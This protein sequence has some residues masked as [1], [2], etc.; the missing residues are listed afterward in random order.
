MYEQ[1]TGSLPGIGSTRNA[2]SRQQ[3]IGF[4]GLGRMGSAMAANLASAGHRITAY[5]RHHDQMDKMAKLG[6]DPTA[7]ITRLFGCEIVISM[8]PDD[9]A[10]RDVVFGNKDA[11]AKVWPR[12][13]RPAPVISRWSRSAPRRRLAPRASMRVASWYM[14]QRRGF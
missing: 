6:L 3:D 13:S 12:A 7:D 11:R 1:Q 8:L 14:W 5:V 9:D 2:L 4:V 10:V